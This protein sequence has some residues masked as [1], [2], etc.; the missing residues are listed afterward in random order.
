[1]NSSKDLRILKAELLIPINRFR[2]ER[3]RSMSIASHSRLQSRVE[4]IGNCYVVHIA[5][6]VSKTS[7]R[8][9]GQNKRGKMLAI[10]NVLLIINVLDIRT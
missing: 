3:G 7:S 4:R 10:A 8:D 2:A 9:L 1:M 5:R 6:Q